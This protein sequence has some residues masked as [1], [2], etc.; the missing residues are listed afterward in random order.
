MFKGLKVKIRGIEPLLCNN[1]A[2]ADPMNHLQKEK[3]KYTGKRKKTDADHIQIA[4]L[5][6]LGSLY[7]KDGRPVMPGRNLEAM[8]AGKG[9]A[10]RKQKEGQKAKAGI[11]VH[12]SW[13]LIYDGPTDPEELWEDGRFRSTERVNVQQSANMRTRAIF[14]DWACEYT[15]L[16]DP[17]VVNLEDVIEW[18]H[19]AGQGGLGDWRPRYG[20]FEVESVEEI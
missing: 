2:A 9:G 1:G 10:A 17:D 19:M 11:R 6:F 18:L 7:M 14:T 15:M 12:G 20:Q 3:K 13:P 8:I 4:K 5:D 16:Y